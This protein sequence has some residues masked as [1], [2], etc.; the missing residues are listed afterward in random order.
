MKTKKNIKKNQIFGPKNGRFTYICMSNIGENHTQSQLL[1]RTGIY[2]DITAAQYGYAGM[3]QPGI[4]RCITIS[5]SICAARALSVQPRLYLCLSR[6]LS[7]KTNIDMS[8]N[9]A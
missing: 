3:N 2:Q 5:D 6:T 1:I 4:A 8:S 9:E 7:V